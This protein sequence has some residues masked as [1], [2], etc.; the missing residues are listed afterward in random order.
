[1]FILLLWSSYQGTTSAPSTEPTSAEIGGIGENLF[2][3]SLNAVSFEDRSLLK[4]SL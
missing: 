4:I 3:S 2:S 1:M